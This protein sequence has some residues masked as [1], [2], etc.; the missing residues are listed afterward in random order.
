MSKLQL[1][2]SAW[3]QR[4]DDRN[5]K[6]IDDHETNET[7]GNP[8]NTDNSENYENSKKLMIS[9]LVKYMTI[10]KIVKYLTIGK[11]VKRMMIV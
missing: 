1:K 8:A 2:L 10:V 11:I 7:L 5:C 6:I 3:F 4:N 9:N